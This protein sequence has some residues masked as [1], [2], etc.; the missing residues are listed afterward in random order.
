MCFLMSICCETSEKARCTLIHLY[1]PNKDCPSFY[2]NI[3]VLIESID[4]TEIILCGDWYFARHYDLDT[5]KYIRQNN[6]KA[7]ASIDNLLQAFELKRLSSIIFLVTPAMFLT[8]KSCSI[9][10]RYESDRTPI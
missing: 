5:Y 7:K 9:D 3:D 2:E 4:N 6:P 10:T 8:V 1:G